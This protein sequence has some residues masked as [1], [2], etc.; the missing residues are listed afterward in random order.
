MSMSTA[1]SIKQARTTNLLVALAPI[2]VLI[3]GLRLAQAFF[4]KR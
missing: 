2:V 4:V 3:A 1:S